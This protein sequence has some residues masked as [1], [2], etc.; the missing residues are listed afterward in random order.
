MT[1]RELL[2]RIDSRE[3]TEWMAFYELEPW[4]SEIDDHRAGTIAA[5]IANVNRDPKKKSMPYTWDDF[6]DRGSSHTE[7]DLETNGAMWREFIAPFKK[8]GA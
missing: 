6:F 2:A 7:Y 3:L 1:V 4:G 5:T 8:G